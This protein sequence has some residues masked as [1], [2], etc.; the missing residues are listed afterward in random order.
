PEQVAQIR[1]AAAALYDFQEAARVTAER[2]QAMSGMRQMVPEIAAEDQMMRELAA[3]QEML[4]AKE[5]SDQQYRDLKRASEIA[6]NEEMMRIEEE[7][8]RAQ[9]RGNEFMMNSIDALGQASTDVIS[10]ILSGTMNTEEAMQALG[11]AIFREAIGAIV[12]M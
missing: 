10:G 2:A 4:A 5:I 8:F 12:Q 11:Q 7:R 9:S 3:Y 1:E 6:Y